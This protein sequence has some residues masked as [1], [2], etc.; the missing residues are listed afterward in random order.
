[1]FLP[2]VQS[3]G[4]HW[5]LYARFVDGPF[6]IRYDPAAGRLS[7]AVRRRYPDTLELW[8]P[9]AEEVDKV[10]GLPTD[11][12][13]DRLDRIEGKLSGGAYDVRI[14][15]IITGR[16]GE[17]LLFCWN[18]GKKDVKKLAKTLMRANPGV[19]YRYRL[20]RGDDFAYYNKWLFSPLYE[21]RWIMNHS[22]C[23]SLIERGE[24]FREPRE[25]GFWCCFAGAEHIRRVADRLSESGY[26]VSPWERAK[27]GEYWLRFSLDAIPVCIWITGYT[28]HILELLEG[29]DG[30]LGGWGCQVLKEGEKAA[31]IRG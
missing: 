22:V 13:T 20:D 26:R 8:I 9:L 23:D 1:M 3:F 2:G 15:G 10:F 31:D 4:E 28:S 12:E 30:Y 17:H 14:V 11:A 21:N 6:F 7:E 29:T 27:T 19:P 25:I 24:A 18:A 16:D 5:R